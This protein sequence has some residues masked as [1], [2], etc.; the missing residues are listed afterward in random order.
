MAEQPDSQLYSDA[1]SELLR[2]TLEQ[3][4][5]EA[6]EEIKRLSARLGEGDFAPSSQVATATERLAL[7]QEML[8]MQQSLDAKE[9]ALDHI[10]EECRRL[11]DAMEDKHLALEGLRKELDRKEQSLQEAHTEIDRLRQELLEASRA[12]E[13]RAAATPSQPVIVRGGKTPRWLVP[14]TG[15]LAVLLTVSA[16]ANLYLMRDRPETPAPDRNT[17]VATV[18]VERPPV[19]SVPSGPRT[20]SAPEPK[21]SGPPA[22][23]G[24]TQ[25]PRI[26]QDRLRDGTPGPA[27]VVLAGGAFRM[28][29]NSLGGEDF[30]PARSVKVGPFMMAA[31]EVTFLEYDRF[32]RATGREL[33]DD[34]GWGRGTRPVVGISWEEARDY[35]AWLA[36]QTGRRYRLPSEAEWEFAAR[37]GTTTPFWWGQNADSNRTVC[38]DC[39]SQWDNRSTAPVMSFPAN[40]FGLYETAGN[41]M[42]WVADCY[43]ARYQDAPNDGRALVSGDCASRVARGG[44]FNKPAD[45]MRAF[46]RA[47]FAP[48]TKLNMLGFRVARDPGPT[49]QD[50]SGRR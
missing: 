1:E 23:A 4:R 20:E 24:T 8:L 11:E 46:V 36:Q 49:D 31:H 28:G 6:E 15:L 10:T 30:S 40:P 39:G 17:R 41:A 38:F 18:P 35:T 29:H 7:Q 50:A 3:L 33:P 19:S 42:E 5:Q 22:V 14:T 45:S 32:A 47:R 12:A 2:N 25:P 43:R 9:Q 37:A 21:P 48:D 26:H 44:A 34:Q 27:M 13:Q 16:V